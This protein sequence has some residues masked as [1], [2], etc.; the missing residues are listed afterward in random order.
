MLHQRRWS[1][2]IMLH[3]SDGLLYSCQC[4][5]RAARTLLSGSPVAPRVE[6]ELSYFFFSWWSRR[7]VFHVS[8]DLPPGAALTMQVSWMLW[9]WTTQCD[10]DHHQGSSCSPSPC[11]TVS[12]WKRKCGSVGC[13]WKAPGADLPAPGF[14]LR[15]LPLYAAGR[16]ERLCYCTEYREGRS[17]TILSHGVQRQF[18]LSFV[19]SGALFDFNR[20][21][22]FSK[23]RKRTM[24]I[25]SCYSLNPA[26]NL[27]LKI[28]FFSLTIMFGQFF[29]IIIIISFCYITPQAVTVCLC[30]RCFHSNKE[31]RDTMLHWL[32]ETHP[33]SSP[34]MCARLFKS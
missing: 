20:S 32:R 7:F 16:G 21:S 26:V 33:E 15:P 17:L 12:Q 28:F 5:R 27:N 19:Y 31:L 25:L 2:W 3:T 8:S 6:R 18:L 9:L 14:S 10:G 23:S 11:K 24:W 13:E 30:P 22:S 4:S 29:I 34:H 1:R